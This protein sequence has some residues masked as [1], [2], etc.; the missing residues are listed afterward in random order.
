MLKFHSII[1]SRVYN[2]AYQH[3][4]SFNH[5]YRACTLSGTMLS[6]VLGFEPRL[7]ELKKFFSVDM[8]SLTRSPDIS[9]PSSSIFECPIS[10]Y[11]APS[12]CLI[13]GI[14]PTRER[15]KSAPALE[16]LLTS[17]PE[18]QSSTF[19]PLQTLWRDISTVLDP[20]LMPVPP[21]FY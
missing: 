2:P 12:L 20:R 17:W 8:F 13:L 19:D 10:M 4:H 14:Q 9:L 5:F 1:Y 3:T 11:S 7:F 16:E 15:Q 6:S 18:S 21:N